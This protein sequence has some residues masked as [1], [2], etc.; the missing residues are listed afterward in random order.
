VPFSRLALTDFRSYASVQIEAGPAFV[1]LFGENGAGK[2][3]LLEA[4]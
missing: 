1:P 2:P 4:G 3:N